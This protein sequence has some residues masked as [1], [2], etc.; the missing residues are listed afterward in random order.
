MKYDWVDEISQISDRFEREI[1]NMNQK[2]LLAL[3]H[4]ATIYRED[5]EE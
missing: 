3:I 5:D 4:L 1:M 2:E